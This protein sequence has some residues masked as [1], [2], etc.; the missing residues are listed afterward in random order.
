[1]HGN[2]GCDACIAFMT[3]YVPICHSVSRVVSHIELCRIRENRRIVLDVEVPKDY[4]SNLRPVS[5]LIGISVF[6]F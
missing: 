2:R 1:M 6:T 5:R 4:F 3:T